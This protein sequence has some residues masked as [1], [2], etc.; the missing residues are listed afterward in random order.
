MKNSAHRLQ[1]FLGGLFLGL[2]CAPAT[3]KLLVA[4]TCIFTASSFLP[5]ATAQ[6]ETRNKIFEG[7]SVEAFEEE[8]E[9]ISEESLPAPMS[10]RSS[11]EDD[12]N[13]VKEINRALATKIKLAL[14][15]RV[16]ALTVD[17]DAE[18]NYI[19]LQ[20]SVHSEEERQRAQAVAEEYTGE[21]L[22]VNEIEIAEELTP[23]TIRLES[24]LV[25]FIL[26]GSVVTCLIVVL[27]IYLGKKN[28]DSE[29]HVAEQ[30]DSASGYQDSGPPRPEQIHAKTFGDKR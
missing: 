10:E 3:I 26:T 8:S 14:D 12:T 20:G 24:W 11:T 4:V 7:A 17:V 1:T 25:Y 28:E 30:I 22:V 2:T 18:G 13:E 29:L 19:I 16:S 27:V 23:P 21:T 6:N 9:G 15:P 5:N